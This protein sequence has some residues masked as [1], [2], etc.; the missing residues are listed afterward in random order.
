MARS[1]RRH[2]RDYSLYGEAPRGSGD[3]LLHAE[4]IEARS[5]PHHWK[6]DTHMH[7]GLHQLLLLLR[8]RAAA[9][10]EGGVAHFGPPAFMIVPAGVVHS[11]E[12]E[13][14]TLGFVVTLADVLLR[15]AA[16]RDAAVAGLFDAPLGSELDAQAAVTLALVRAFRTLAREHA[17]AAPA[18]ALAL[19]GHLAVLLAAAL[20]AAQPHLQSA[21][22][23]LSGDRELVAR[24]R[25]AIEK[26]FRSGRSVPEYA[27]ALRVSEA[28]LRQSCL[29]ATG[30]PPIRLV[31]ARALLEAKRK[32]VYTQLPVAEIAYALG[33]SDPAYFTRFFT[34]R[35]G[36]SPRAYRCGGHG[37]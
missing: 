36:I 1:A 5:L 2:I 13:P 22:P 6:I 21:D 8:G 9:R 35:A 25:E 18:R 15:E 29:R 20:R 26:D 17:G 4:T 30:H 12:F 28:R 24:L 3:R 27:R 16:H 34:S 31:H 19:E 23:R 10:T 33:F 37:S 7:R 14:G 11:F 32:L